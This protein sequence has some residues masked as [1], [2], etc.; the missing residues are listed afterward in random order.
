MERIQWKFN[1]KKTQWKQLLIWV[2]FQERF[3]SLEFFNF[4]TFLSLWS[5]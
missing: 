4:W 5:K 1:K 2:N 3:Q